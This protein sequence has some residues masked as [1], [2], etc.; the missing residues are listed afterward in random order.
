LT[1]A[2]VF[3]VNGQDGSYLAELL[4]RKGVEVIGWVPSNVPI[5]TVNISHILEEIEL[6]K[7]NL[8]DFDSL[9]ESIDVHKPDEIYNLASPSSPHA[10]W[11]SSL[12][13]S[14]VTGMGA[15]RLLE[16]IRIDCPNTRFYQASSSEIFGNPEEEPQNEDT[17]FR[18]R[19]PY[20]IAKLFA[21]CMTMQYRE[22]YGLYAVS[23]ILYN[24]ESP[25]RGLDFVTRKIT[26]TAAKI[27]LGFETKLRLGNLEARR[28]WGY[29]K[30]YSEA[31]WLMMHQ[32][33]PEDYVIG[34]G[35]THSVR[36]FC[37]LAFDLL[38]LDY[39]DYVVCDNRFFRPLEP[40]QMVANFS[41]AANNLKWEPKTNFKTLVKLMVEADL[42]IA[43]SHQNREFN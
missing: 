40:K 20:G 6:I 16:V 30:D 41:K 11:Q 21:H 22:K 33:S 17:P 14:D 12:E 5:S 1:K 28:D 2:L 13:V 3:G 15:A 32:N 31:I 39:R 7:G 9:R 18:P 10:S 19:N 35:E 29:A 37:E 26:Y 24:H 38:D 36:E 27:K 23:G 34:S 25:R 43:A 8:K 4:I 42:E